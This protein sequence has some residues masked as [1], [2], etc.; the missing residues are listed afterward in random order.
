MVPRRPSLTH[1]RL[2]KGHVHGLL[3][4]FAAR[5]PVIALTA[6]PKHLEAGLRLD[7]CLQ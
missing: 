6:S 3:G 4:Q 1:A 2:P 5:Q 7:A